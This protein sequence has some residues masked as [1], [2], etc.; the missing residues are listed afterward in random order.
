MLKLSEQV[1]SK[2]SAMFSQLWF[3]CPKAQGQTW[4]HKSRSSPLAERAT[5]RLTETCANPTRGRTLPAPGTVSQKT[6]I[7]LLLFLRKFTSP[8]TLQDGNPPSPSPPASSSLILCLSPRA[9]AS[10]KLSC[11]LS[12]GTRL[13]FSFFF[14]FYVL[15]CFAFTWSVPILVIKDKARHQ[16]KESYFFTI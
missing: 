8:E 2:A 5:G 7:L 3:P 13:P 4:A 15:F 1:S 11:F 10:R 14:S 12:C 16:H 6:W 9:G